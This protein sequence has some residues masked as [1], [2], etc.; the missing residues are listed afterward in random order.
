MTWRGQ[1]WRERVSE[2]C[3]VSRIRA[4][5]TVRESSDTLFGYS[6]TSVC[7]CCCTRG[8]QQQSIRRVRAKREK[9]KGNGENADN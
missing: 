6:N 5:T 9:T 4:E 8:V 3:E 7:M 1:P 2:E